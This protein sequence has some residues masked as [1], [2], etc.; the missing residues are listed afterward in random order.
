MRTGATRP[1]NENFGGG[2]RSRQTAQIR[3]HL[4]NIVPPCDPTA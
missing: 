3:G 1:S 4:K 2:D